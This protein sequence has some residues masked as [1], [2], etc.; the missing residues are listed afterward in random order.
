MI[1]FYPEIAAILFSIAVLF[2]L[3]MVEGAL[4]EASAVTLR[5]SLEHETGK[6]PPLLPLVIENKAHLFLPLHLGIQLALM[7]MAILITLVSMQSWPVWGAACA[8]G[9]SLGAS[10]LFRQL[11][12]RLMTQNESENFSAKPVT[13]STKN[14]R[15]STMCWAS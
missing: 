14:P 12:P 2:L 8:F 13:T 3:S 4:I 5:M 1:Y 9:L 15:M 11:L 10:L 6:I 7:F